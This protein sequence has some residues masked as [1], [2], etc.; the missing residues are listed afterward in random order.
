MFTG[1]S[2]SIR[3]HIMGRDKLLKN[4]GRNEKYLFIITFDSKSIPED[5][6]SLEASCKLP[7]N[8]PELTQTPNNTAQSQN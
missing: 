1:A 7:F 6:Q 5:D 4:L 2:V 3:K 8:D